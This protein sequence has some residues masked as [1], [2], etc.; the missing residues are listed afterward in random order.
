MKLWA[1]FLP[2][3]YCDGLLGTVVFNWDAQIGAI[4]ELMS[5]GELD[6]ARSTAEALLSNDEIPQSVILELLGDISFKQKKLCVAAGYYFR[7]GENVD[8]PAKQQRYQ[9]LCA[10]TYYQCGH[11]L[12][13][14]KIYEHGCKTDP[15]E[16][17]KFRYFCA[18]LKTNQIEIAQD[19]TFTS[20]RL[21]I[22]KAWNL[23]TYWSKNKIFPEAIDALRPWIQK[24]ITDGAFYTFC[25]QMQYR[26]GRF[27][28]A[29]QTVI[30]GE[31]MGVEKNYRRDLQLLRMR[32]GCRC[33][34]E[35]LCSVAPELV[36]EKRYLLWR[37]L[38]YL[39][40]KDWENYRKSIAA[41]REKFLDLS[42]YIDAHVQ[43]LRGRHSDALMT[44]RDLENL[45][46]PIGPLSHQRASLLTALSI[47]DRKHAN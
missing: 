23:A 24:K 14:L 26:T 15:N 13:A 12:P 40:A 22:R 17:L 7:A 18:L 30:L 42:R 8:D 39:E 35:E 43:M 21:N 20:E 27:E 37:C 36:Q 4:R 33:G 47:C 46:A 10:D 28:D 5:S 25:A 11:Y 31:S 34:R 29:L 1:I 19:I 45:P 38:G 3:L 16:E 6:E 9:V 41:L 44:F 32:I 2:L